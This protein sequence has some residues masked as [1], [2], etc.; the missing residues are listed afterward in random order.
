MAANIDGYDAPKLTRENDVLDRWRF[1]ADLFT[2]VKDTPAD[3]SV[4]I[5]IF[6]KWGEG[7][8]T[9]LRFLEQMA[10]KERY[11]PVRFSP[12]SAHTWDD[13]WGE[14]ATVLVS[15]LESH[16][17]ATK[18]VRKLKLK[19]L[20]KK[21]QKN[22]K[23]VTTDLAA[24][25]AYTKAGAGAGFSLLQQFLD[26]DGS[27]FQ[28]LHT[29]LGG[30]RIIL[31]IDDLDRA[32]PRL[33]PQLLLALR[34]LLDLPGFIFVLAFDDSIVSKALTAYHPA[35]SGGDAFLE[36]ILDFRF[37]LP[38]VT[39]AQV[40]KLFER[41]LRTF[42]P[43]VNAGAVE[44]V[45]DLL[46]LNPRKVKALIRQ[47]TALK[48]EVSR[49]DT[50][51]LN[52]VDITIA[53]LIR[54]ESEGFFEAM[55]RSSRLEDL[56]F[57][58]FKARRERAEA[59]GK[60]DHELELD[61]LLETSGVSDAVT[62]ERIRALM[63]AQRARGGFFFRSQAE[64]STR[65][66]LITSREF[67]DCVE[68]CRP[69]RQSVKVQKWID[70]QTTRRSATFDE[71]VVELFAMLM[72]YRE[73]KLDAA[74]DAQTLDEHDTA[75]KEAQ[76]SLVL[77]RQVLLG[78]IALTARIL[79]SP[80]SFAKIFDQSL[81]WLHFDRN[82]SEPAVR[83][84][85]HQF[86]IEIVNRHL[87]AGANAYLDVLRPWSMEVAFDAG[88]IDVGSA[89]K[90]RGLRGDLIA[91]V[92]P[93]VAENVLNSLRKPNG[94]SRLSEKGRGLAE[95]YVLLNPSSRLWADPVKQKLYGILK[96]VGDTSV[97]REN[98]LALFELLLSG[99]KSNLE[100][101]NSEDVKKLIKDE[102][103]VRAI[104]AGAV[105][106]RIQYRHQMEFLKGRDLLVT[107][108]AA[109]SGMPLPDWL[110]E[111]LREQTDRPHQTEHDSAMDQ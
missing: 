84:E 16:G 66:P 26:V 18:T 48:G 13:L 29:E 27:D 8:T 62:K 99:L 42:C 49:H 69:D 14:F 74:A 64:L 111:R 39:P 24:V 50:D 72:N 67:L 52:W 20:G 6:A 25:S 95:K 61:D 30:R 89:A 105:S 60:D 55:L 70:V 77:L 37:P 40:W 106:R 31:F 93:A 2:I 5:G 82:P 3:W 110:A 45:A 34:E 57:S 23:S 101:V 92:E 100:S 107:S 65:P 79:D 87:D 59:S 108:G 1:A 73:R 41:S 96:E 35:W 21:V 53:Q 56:T 58:A 80:S 76:L 54:L 85:E 15:S 97:G 51:E 81:K 90:R 71:V 88:A 33:V 46:P 36:K 11:L 10:V 9:V 32:D 104:W 44:Q 43:F 98:C 7:K 63:E 4:R 83:A 86:L 28:E 75:I 17:A 68:A 19:L 102:T 91:I 78:E 94:I 109:E 103:F 22:L 38:R 12:W 47:L